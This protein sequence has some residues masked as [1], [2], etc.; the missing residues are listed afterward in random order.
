[1][2]DVTRT[3][4]CGLT[5]AEDVRLAVELG[6]WAVGF[7][8]STPEQAASVASLADGVIVGSVLIDTVTRA[9]SPA[10][11]CDAAARLVGAA[12]AAIAGA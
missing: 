5:R 2:A 7:G 12:S 3:K 8:I 10:E 4:V 1:M 6:A 11:A 9:S